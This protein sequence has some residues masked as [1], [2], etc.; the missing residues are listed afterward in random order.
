MARGTSFAD[1]CRSRS[2]TTGYVLAMTP[3]SAMTVCLVLLACACSAARPAARPQSAYQPGQEYSFRARPGDPAPRFVVLKVEAR[4]QVGTIVHI[5]VRGVRIA[6]ANAP[7]GYSDHVGHSPFTEAAID[8]SD[9]TL[10]ATGVALPDFAEGYRLW[11]EASDR[12]EAGVFSIPLSEYLDA[13][14]AIVAEAR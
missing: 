12:G 7:S 14:E 5:A 11:R 3:R 10:E 9:V 1:P 8:R 2:L 13:M 6:N 4:P